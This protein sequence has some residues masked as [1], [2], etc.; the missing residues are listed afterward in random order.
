MRSLLFRFVPALCLVLLSSACGS[1]A[2][3]Q[4]PVQLKPGLYKASYSA[5]I[6][7]PLK[8]SGEGEPAGKV[9]VSPD[10]AA[11]FPQSYPRKHFSRL[12]ASCGG[13]LT[14]RVG[15]R[16]TGKVVCSNADGGPGDVTFEFEGDVAEEAVDVSAKLQLRLPDDA[17]AA[18]ELDPSALDDMRLELSLRRVGDCPA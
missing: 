8:H 14:E 17:A 9:C 15:N 10:E 11:S 1:D 5:S 6:Y 12:G 7:T 16:I 4:A 13:P 2:A 3:T 18:G